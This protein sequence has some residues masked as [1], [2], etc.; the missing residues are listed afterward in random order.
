MLSSGDL[1]SGAR[2]QGTAVADKSDYRVWCTRSVV[3]S[4]VGMVTN[5]RL[6]P[7]QALR[8]CLHAV[9]ANKSCRRRMMTVHMLS[10]GD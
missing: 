2:V 6:G 4:P 3:H 9:L 10:S 8:M 7:S 1:Q 5:G